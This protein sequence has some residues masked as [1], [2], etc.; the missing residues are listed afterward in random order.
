LAV[1]GTKQTV[2][3]AELLYG[4]AAGLYSTQTW[5]TVEQAL[6]DAT[7]GHGS[8]I[9]NLFDDY[10][11]LQSNGTYQNTFEAESAVDCLDA[12]APTVSQL[13]A[14]GR[15]LEPQA[16]VFGLL[17]LYSEM[18]CSVWPVKATGTAHP[19]HADGSPPIVVVGSTG[20][21]VT[22]YAW[23]VSLAHE[24]Q[25]GVLLTRVGDGH[26]A[27]GSSSCVQSAVDTYLIDLKA[28]P[29]GDRC[30]SDD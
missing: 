13:V 8:G 9:L 17:D 2:G 3:P 22:P 7:A 24:L 19:I 25:H 4:T 14:D 15:V 21:P 28:P 10:V 26:T 12:P 30:P 23:A 5:S 29:A 6:A 1:S 18:T 11:G 27:Y 20:D 16:P